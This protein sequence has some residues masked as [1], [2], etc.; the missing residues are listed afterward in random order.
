MSNKKI[1]TYTVEL[2]VLL[3]AVAGL[4]HLWKTRAPLPTQSSGDNDEDD[5]KYKPLVP[6]NVAPI[7]RKTLRAYLDAYGTV[8]PE[9]AIAGKPAAV[10]NLSAPSVGLIG[11]VKCLEGQQVKQ[12]DACCSHRT[13]GM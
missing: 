7:E 8:E 12:G 4:H 2:L 13:T 11:T 6:V 9:P 10:A 5:L 1:L 3:V